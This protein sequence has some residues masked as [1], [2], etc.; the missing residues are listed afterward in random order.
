MRFNTSTKLASLALAAALIGVAP[1]SFAATATTTMGVTATVLST[2]VAVATPV[3][4]G[5]YSL[6]ALDA[7][8]L[9]TVT[10]TPDVLAY[11]VGMDAGTGAGATTSARKMTSL[12]STDTL[13]YS[14]YRDTG[15]TQNWGNAAG[16][17]QASSAATT[18]VGTIKTFSVYGR[19][20]SNQTATLGAYLDTIQ[21]TV[22]Y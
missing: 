17:M 21:V 8:G 16:D 14:L 20:T 5:N 15:R 6:S 7:S 22:N 19:L 18:T 9:V 3:T 2:C 1:V 11:N 10:C 12:T 4:F 13:S